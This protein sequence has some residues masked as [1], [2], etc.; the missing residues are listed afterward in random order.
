MYKVKITI[1]V[2]FI[3]FLGINVATAQNPLIMDQFTADPTARVFDGKVYVYPSHDVNCG[4]DWFCMKDYHVFSSENLIDWTDHGVIV[5]QKEVEWVNSTGNSMW[6]PDAIEKDGKYYFYFPSVADTNSGERGFKIGVAVSDNP[7]G[8]FEPEKTPIEGI[9]GI[10]PGIFIDNDGQAYISWSGRGNLVIAKL[11]DNMKELA[12]EP[13]VVEGVPK[14]GLSEGPF[15]FERNGIYYFTYPLVI[16][17][18]EALV[19]ATGD[20]PLGPFEYKGVFM[21][22]HPS[23]CWTNHHSMIEYK[24]QWYLFYHHNDLSPDFDKNRSIRAEK[25]YFNEDGTIQKVIP[26]LRGVGITPATHKIQIDRYSVISTTGAAI[27]FNN[28]EKTF[29]GWKTELTKENGWVR[30]NDVDFGDAALKGVTIRASSESGATLEVIMTNSIE[31]KR[32]SVTIPASNDWNLVETLVDDLPSGI[33]HI[34]VV[35]TSENT[36][37]VDWVQFN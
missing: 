19:Y 12:S 23:S 27:S 29:D 26:T 7:Y 32:F 10:D 13:V 21:D 22:E 1:L 20:N 6:A 5:D 8:P 25:L 17:K 3:S 34:K 31:T 14:T 11:K 30:Y 2:L 36:A 28:P 16:E 4:T 37:Y 24:D 15:M 33:Q 35:L 18:T 9:S